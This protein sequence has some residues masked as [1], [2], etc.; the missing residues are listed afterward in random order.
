MM[1]GGLPDGYKPGLEDVIAGVSAISEV[2]AQKDALTYAGYV[3][4]E[5]AAKS[6]YV[7]VAYL[8]LHHR[9]P[10]ASELKSFSIATKS[11]SLN[12]PSEHEHKMDESV[13]VHEIFSQVM[14]AFPVGPTCEMVRNR[15][16]FHVVVEFSCKGLH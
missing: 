1:N 2:D 10:N 14:E 15:I 12:I 13:G 7:D 5:L 4:H 8:L 16:G 11:T 9:L 3:A 6:T